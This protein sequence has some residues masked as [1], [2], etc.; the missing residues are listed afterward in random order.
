MKTALGLDQVAGFPYQLSP[1]KKKT[2]LPI[3]AVDFT[4]AVPSLKKVF[5]K[6]INI[7]VMSDLYFTTKFRY[8]F[9]KT[10]LRHTTSVESKHWLRGPDM[11]YWAQQLNFAVFCTTQG[12]GISCD[13]FNNGINL[14]LQIRAFH[15][16]PRVFHSQAHFVPARR[17]SEHKRFARSD[18]QSFE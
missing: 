9:Q 18:I 7:C 5:N 13:I 10:K 1:M 11:K 16:L 2:A 12:F 3:P 8:I 4:K 6:P 14:P 17:Y 15:N